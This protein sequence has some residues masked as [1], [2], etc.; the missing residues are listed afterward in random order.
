[1][2]GGSRG[3]LPQCPA[4]SSPSPLLLQGHLPQIFEPVTHTGAYL[5]TSAGEPDPGTAPALQQLPNLLTSPPPSP[6][7][8]QGQ[9]TQPFQWHREDP[10]PQMKSKLFLPLASAGNSTMRP[11]SLCQLWFK[12]TPCGSGDPHKA[13]TGL[14]HLKTDSPRSVWHTEGRGRANPREQRAQE[15]C[16][17]HGL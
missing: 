16:Q 6:P 5:N 13:D 8:M 2:P 10:H 9:Q 17:V 3:G 7:Q 1:M 15:R 11:S 12:G 4:T 14:E